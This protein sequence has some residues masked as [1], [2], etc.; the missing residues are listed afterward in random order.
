M[1]DARVEPIKIA[2][3]A[4]GGEG[5]GVLANW[6]VDVAEHQGADA[7]TTSVPGVAQRTGATIY[8]VEVMVTGRDA[9]RRPVL[10]LMPTPGD[11]DVVIASEL[12]E[13]A[14]AVQR[15]LVTPEKTTLVASSHRVYTLQEKMSMGDG[16]ISPAV[17]L[18]RCTREAKRVILRDFA[19]IADRSGSV[20]SATLFGALAASRTLPWPREAFEEAIR[21]GG[22]GVEPSLRAFDAAYRSTLAH[23]GTDAVATDGSESSERIDPRLADL[24]S[25]ARRTLPAAA[26]SVVRAGVL[27]TAD[28]QGQEYAARYLDRVATI[29]DLDARCGDGSHRLLVEG[30]RHLALWMTYED[31][32]RVAE[33]KLRRSRFHR[34]GLGDQAEAGTLR[35]VEEYLHPRIEEL[36]DAAPAAIG[37]WMLRSRLTRVL[38][39]PIV[40]RGRV[41]RTSTLRGFLLLYLMAAC[42]TWRPR[43]LRFVRETLA[44]DAW[45]ARLHAVAPTDYALACELAECPRL[46]KGYGDTHARGRRNYE[47][48]S[49][50]L[51][52]LGP[53][54][55]DRLRSLRAAALEDESGATLERT[56]KEFGLVPHG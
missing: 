36:A 9:A 1:P 22:V 6:I 39:G 5:G 35:H 30:A 10:A 52:R 31:T 12:M 26:H 17:F 44:L 50:V 11:V 45:L 20:I 34:V 8:Y 21:R 49:N 33:L 24:W 47:A 4:M 13:A 16:R 42:R 23:A 15:G 14:R 28:Y 7:Q 48:I 55:A 41:V 53:R 25:R 37:A 19:E 3:L 43:S 51:D 46:L 29:V 40:G 2:V 32:A 56:L 54:A 38:V 18:E 27:R